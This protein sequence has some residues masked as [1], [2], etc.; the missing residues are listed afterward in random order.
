MKKLMILMALVVSALTVNAQMAA[1]GY[2]PYEF[3]ANYDHN[4][5]RM[6]IKDIPT[7]NLQLNTTFFYDIIH[8]SCFYTY[9]Y[10]DTM[11]VANSFEY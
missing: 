10:F 9:D 4:G 7:I 8:C 1:G 5:K 6:E 3:V 2:G 11:L